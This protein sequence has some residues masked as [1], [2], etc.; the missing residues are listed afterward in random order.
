MAPVE[1]LPPFP[2]RASSVGY[3]EQQLSLLCNAYARLEAGE[4]MASWEEYG[5]IL[6]HHNLIESRIVM[7]AGFICFHTHIKPPY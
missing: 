2:V 4:V 6:N 7:M 3:G 5:T 1:D